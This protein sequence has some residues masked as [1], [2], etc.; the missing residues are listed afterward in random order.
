MK[1]ASRWLWLLLLL[2]GLGQFILLCQAMLSRIFYPYDLEWM[3][4]G[5]L[6]HAQRIADGAGIYV[7]PSVDFIPFLYTPLYPGIMAMLSPLADIGYGV[8][9]G[10]SVLSILALCAIIVVINRRNQTPETRHLGWIGGLCSIGII[11]AAYPFME[12]WYDLVRADSLFML[13]IVGGLFGVR[14]WSKSEGQAGLAKLGCAAALLGLS[15][16][17]K[18]TGVLF[19]AAGGMMVLA[20]NWRR[21]PLYVGV[22]GTIGL[23]G[24]YLLNEVTNGWFWIYVYKTHQYH[25]FNMKRFYDSFGKILWQ[26]P[27]MTIIIAIAA[28]ALALTFALKRK[29][30]SS[31]SEFVFWL[32]IFVVSVVVGAVGWGTQ[33]AH[34]NAYMP[35]FIIGAL[36]SGLAVSTLGGC[37]EIWGQER[38]AV[39][40]TLAGYGAPLALGIQLLLAWW[41]PKTFVPT[42]AD[43]EAGHEL[44][45]TLRAIEGEILIPYHPWYAHLAD[46]PVRVHLMGLRDMTSGKVWPIR[47]L[48][49]AIRE[50][51]FAAIIMDNR[52]FGRELSQV[53]HFYRLD[54]F[55]PATASPHVYTGAGA[56]YSPSR[57]VPRSVWVPNGPSKLPEGARV[58][59]DFEN[60]KLSNWL[61]EKKHKNAWGRAPVSRALPKQGP[62]RHYGGKYYLSSFHGGDKGVGEL[63]SPEFIIEGSRLTFRLSGGKDDKKLRAELHIDGTVHRTATGTNSERMEE[64]AWS[65]AAY[66]GKTAQIVLIDSS[67]GSWGHL[68]V[69]EFWSWE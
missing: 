3:E 17:A 44:I 1:A 50:Q 28:G 47:G 61:P 62:V 42:A 29:F 5:L 33:F 8:G 58:L 59:W 4:G 40:R 43:R 19:V 32:P 46:K 56:F 51:K 12:G 24:T 23:G 45:R 65:V 38:R 54:D 21:T 6:A 53:K 22:T 35:A 55:L 39:W 69:D 41:T 13:M 16:F 26:F 48:P 66:S 36:C 2:P 68:N 18:Q 64:I 37:I 63:R 20:A 57:L 9:R 27:V 52:P 31:A 67:K 7:D 34:F 10:I 49:E 14:C 15:F 30:P 25:D 60:G 11:A